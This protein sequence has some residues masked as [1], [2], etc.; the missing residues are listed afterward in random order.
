[1]L[2][3]Q[4]RFP[5]PIPRSPFTVEVEEVATIPDSTP[6]QP[7]RVSVLTQ[8]PAGR[9]FAND[10]R[11]PLY[12]IDPRSGRVF[13]FLDLR[14]FPELAI[15]ST[16]EA[17]FQSFAFHPSFHDPDSPGFGRLY[18]LHSTTNTARRPDF[19]PGGNTSLHELLLEWRTAD[20]GQRRF[21]A[22]D[23]ANPYRELLRFKHPFGNHNG[24]LIVFNPTVTPGDA[25]YGNLYLAMGDGGAGG[26][27]Q[28]N[29]EDPSNPFGAI[30]RIDP[31]GNDASNG[32]YG[33]VAENRLAADNDPDTLAEIYCY[34][35]RNPQRFGWDIVT[36][37]CFIAD[38][39]QNDVEEI[40]LAANGAHFGWDIREGS[41]PFEGGSTAGL[42]DPVAEYDH[43]SPV[44]D[45]PTNI[46]NRAVTVG[47]VARGT[48]IEHLD[49]MLPISDFPTGLIFLLDVDHDPLDGGQDGLTE[50]LL[51]NGNGPATHFLDLVN[52]ART[53][54][55]LG[56]TNRA[57]LRFSVNTPGQVFLT[58][59]HDGIVRRL[60][61]D[62]EPILEVGPLQDGR[63]TLAFRG[64]L[65]HSSDL[66]SWQDLV[67][68]P[69]ATWELPPDTSAS[70]F[71]S[72]RR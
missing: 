8:D 65:Q 12:N 31:T 16:S 72:I 55:G 25:D 50:L 44:R 47:E 60:K 46:G 20:P 41:F 17:G 4:D 61:P 22:A 34:G 18:T 10:Q 39:G 53:A 32:Q 67:P 52:A 5:D 23:P 36:G 58:N 7:A 6:G 59:K 45:M 49:G 30:L 38:I 13:E 9:L 33:L 37:H 57:D 27:P 15:L 29:G 2:S 40:D 63:T 3:A 19:D 51:R 64:V 43:T 21:V 35:L 68:Q 1:M 62:Q 24:G 71:R 56:S 42:T 54:R 69:P 70:F 26:D 28:E 14:D 48:C 66:Q 11:G